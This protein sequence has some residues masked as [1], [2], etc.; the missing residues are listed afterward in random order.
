MLLNVKT[1]K[2]LVILGICSLLGYTS[3]LMLLGF[4]VKYL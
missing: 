4:M 1:I 3:I 2:V